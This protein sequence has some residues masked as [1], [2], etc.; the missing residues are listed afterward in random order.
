MLIDGIFRF[1]EVIKQSFCIHQYKGKAKGIFGTSE[2]Y[3]QC[4]KC[5]RI[6]H[7]KPPK[8]LMYKEHKNENL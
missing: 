7:H 5:S 8:Q 2:I 4:E 3:Y 6:V 1:I